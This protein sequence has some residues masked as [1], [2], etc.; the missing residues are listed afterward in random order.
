VTF[1]KHLDKLGEICEK[2]TFAQIG[3]K[4]Q[5]K[6]KSTNWA[7]FVENLHILGEICKAF[8]QIGRNLQKQN[9]MI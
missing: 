3:R 1:V 9:C 5:K 8:G 2:Q 7:K 4:L 6:K